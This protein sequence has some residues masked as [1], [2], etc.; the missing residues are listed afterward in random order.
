MEHNQ[1]IRDI[2]SNKDDWIDDKVIVQINTTNKYFSKNDNYWKKKF[3]KRVPQLEKHVDKINEERDILKHEIEQLKQEQS[4][5]ITKLKK[6]NKQL[7]EQ[8]NK[9]KSIGKCFNDKMQFITEFCSWLSIT[10][11]SISIDF[12]TI[13]PKIYGSF[14]RQLFEIPFALGFLNVVFS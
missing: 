12:L 9:I 11:D 13:N 7:V 10:L 1:I 5:V 14:M 6:D 3:F 2:I 4:L 8:Q